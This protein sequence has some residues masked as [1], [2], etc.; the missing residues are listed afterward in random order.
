MIYKDLVIIG[1]GSAGLASALSAY[2]NGV[3]NI[4]ILEKDAQLGGILNQCI[5]NGFGL[6]IFKE[7]LTGPEFALKYIDLIIE[8]GI[9]Y[10]IDSTVISVSKDKVV[11]YSNK[12]EGIVEIKAKAIIFATGCLER[13]AGAIKL[14]GDRCAGI[15]TA[16]LAQKYINID[17]Y[18]VGK[19][20]VILGSGDIGLIMARRLTLE[21]AKVV[22]VAEI[23]PYSNGLKRNIAQCLDDYNI[24]LYLST[25]VKEVRGKN[26]VD[27][28]VISKVDENM[29]YISGSEQIIQCDTLI[30]SVGLLPNV[31][32]MKPLSIPFSKAK[33]PLVNSM[34]ETNLEGVF[35]CGNCLHVHDLVDYVALEAK[36]AGENAA[37]YI[38]NYL[39]KNE[40]IKL[41]NKDHISYIVPDNICLNTSDKYEIKFRV[42]KPLGKSKI[43]IMNNDKIIKSINKIALLPSE[44]EKI[45]LTND[46]IKNLNGEINILIK[47]D[48]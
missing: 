43:I 18:M 48:E 38:K 16:G 3:E 27:S 41:T 21:G 1:G 33:G 24:P 28:I 40:E 13:S 32:L 26:R 5:H 22:L 36:I 19:R 23:M 42:D 35:A 44:M 7:E 20:V 47:E 14:G 17:G 2:E 9:D 8:K 4:I 45:I 11:T 30:L 10:R 34:Y 15:L 6:E 29:N 31:A 39:T 37:Q 12:N 46:D 25:T